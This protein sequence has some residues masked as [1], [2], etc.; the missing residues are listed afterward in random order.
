MSHDA[1]TRFKD[2]VNCT[3]EFRVNLC[4]RQ[5]RSPVAGLTWPASI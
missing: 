5:Q 2:S 3:N 4:L 1:P